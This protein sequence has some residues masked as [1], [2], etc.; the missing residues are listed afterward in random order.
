MGTS[1]EVRASS[2]TGQRLAIILI[3]G[4]LLIVGAYLWGT[5]LNASTE[6]SLSQASQASQFN[7][8][9]GVAGVRS[10][11]TLAL[12]NPAAVASAYQSLLGVAAVRAADSTSPIAAGTLYAGAV[13]DHEDRSALPSPAA[14][15]L[16]SLNGVAAVRALD[17]SQ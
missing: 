17:A 8:L 14:S 12:N 6:P 16:G 5:R 13:L 15:G 4:A 2:R 9:F 10:A 11:D 1:Y 7:T 3:V